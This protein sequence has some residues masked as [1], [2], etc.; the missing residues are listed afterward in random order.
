MLNNNSVLIILIFYSQNTGTEM[1]GKPSVLTASIFQRHDMSV[2]ICILITTIYENVNPCMPTA[3][4]AQHESG[5]V[6]QIMQ[7]SPCPNSMIFTIPGF[8]FLKFIWRFPKV[9]LTSCLAIGKIFKFIQKG[10]DFR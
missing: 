9:R 10:F 8:S 6:P 5:F 7:M 4:V 2:Y 3:I 1:R